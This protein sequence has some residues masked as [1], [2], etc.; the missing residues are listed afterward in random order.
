MADEKE[1]IAR[2]IA[3]ELGDG[4][5]VN[6]GIGLP[7]LVANYLPEGV[8]VV[9]QSENGMLGVDAAPEKGKEDPDLVNAGGKYVTAQKGACCFDSAMSFSII[10]GGHI[11]VAVLGALEVDKKGN[12]ASH[13]VPGKKVSGMGGAMDLA[14]G[15]KKIIIATVHTSNGK[16]KIVDQLSLP[17]TAIGVVDLI[18]TEK[19]VIE[20]TPEGLHLKEIASDTTIDEVINSTGTEL[21]VNPDLKVAAV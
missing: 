18:V 15:A 20:V 5:I 2:R 6:L 1:I 7:T 14:T 10:R 19:A 13:I 12:L 21:I 3:Q 4:D 16:P 8:S 9:T 11:D 17:A